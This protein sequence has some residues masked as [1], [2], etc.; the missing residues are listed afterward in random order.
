MAMA[1]PAADLH[2]FSVDEYERMADVGILPDRRLEL[3]DGLVAAMSPRGERHWYAVALLTRLFCDQCAGRYT[4][5]GECLT[6]RLGPRDARE[7][8]LVLSRGNLDGVRRR[9]GPEDVALL[10]EVADSS[11]AYDLGEKK[12]AYA[13]AGIPEYWVVDLRHD[14]VVVCREPLR[15]DATYS[16]ESRH[17]PGATLHPAEYANVAIDVRRILGLEDT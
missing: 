16:L 6:L 9:P 8:D 15:S 3:I 4:V 2:R 13:R 1:G 5:S 14:V 7:P 10:I 17:G 11:L 12:A